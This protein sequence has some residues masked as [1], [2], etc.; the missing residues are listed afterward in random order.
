MILIVG[1][2]YLETWPEFILLSFKNSLVLLFVNFSYRCGRASSLRQLAIQTLHESPRL[3]Q[4]E[5]WILDTWNDFPYQPGRSM[6]RGT[7]SPIILIDP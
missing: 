3:M 4:E 7:I 1:R 6:K 2:G 5:A